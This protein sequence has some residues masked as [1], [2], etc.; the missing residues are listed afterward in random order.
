MITELNV[1]I[2]DKCVLSNF[3]NKFCLVVGMSKIYLFYVFCNKYHQSLILFNN[4]T[5]I[6]SIMKYYLKL[7]LVNSKKYLSTSRMVS[8][9][10]NFNLFKSS[11]LSLLLTKFDPSKFQAMHFTF[12]INEGKER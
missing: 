3:L 6:F 7:P 1:N 2:S 5:N 4:E 9:F 8:P 11:I 10:S 12:D